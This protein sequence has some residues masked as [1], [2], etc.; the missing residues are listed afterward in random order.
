MIDPT[1]NVIFGWSARCGHT[2]IKCLFNYLS[3]HPV[4]NN[5]SNTSPPIS[6]LPDNLQNYT[7]VLFIMNPF[8]RVVGAFLN[9]YTKYGQRRHLW[10]YG[11]CCFRDLV[12]ELCKKN[13]RAISYHHFA[14]QTAHAFDE[15]KLNT[16]GNLVVYN[17]ENIDYIF[18]ETLFGKKI[19]KYIIDYRGLDARKV[20]PNTYYMP[21]PDLDISEYATMNV[22]Y[23]LFYDAD[24]KKCIHNFYNKDFIFLEKHNYFFNFA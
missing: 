5:F 21:V 1:H 4:V 7:V 14:P 8:R 13:W 15:Q 20:Y 6:G 2:H 17:I 23:N 3:T 24:I 11:K 19:P 18:L 16:A 22:D 9:K 10:P 12:A